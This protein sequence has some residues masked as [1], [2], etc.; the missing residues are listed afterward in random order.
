MQLTLEIVLMA[1]LACFGSTGGYLVAGRFGRNSMMWAIFLAL[2]F[3]LAAHHKEP[4]GAFTVPV[5]FGA[6][7]GIPLGFWAGHELG[8]R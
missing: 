4:L 3:L 7:I 5:L 2:A 1:A 8:K 6:L